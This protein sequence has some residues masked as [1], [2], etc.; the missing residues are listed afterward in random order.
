MYADVRR[1]AQSDPATAHAVW[2]QR[3]DELLADH[4]ASP[5]DV[6]A[7]ASFE[8]LDIPHY[9]PAYRFECE[10][11]PAAHQRLDVSTGTDGVVPFE[12]IGTVQVGDLGSL[13]VWVLRG[14]AGGLF[15]PVKDA[16]PDTYGGGRYL[17]D[18]IKG[19]DLG[20]VGDRLVV[21]LNF[22][23][24]PSC[25]YDPAWV[26]PLATRANTLSVE[27]PVGERVFS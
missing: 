18:T 8:G 15:V 3:R 10:V 1:L 23:Y 9:D 4:P 16:A 24:N 6:V 20:M 19:A 5:L 11:L 25:A 7:K 12:R 22:A 21:D 2:V 13:A 27:I 26:C 14:Y 17:L